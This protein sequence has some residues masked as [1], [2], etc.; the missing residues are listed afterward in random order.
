MQLPCQY[1]GH[2]KRFEFNTIAKK[3]DYAPK[4]MQ[5]N[6]KKAAVIFIVS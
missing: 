3:G 5:L 1:T 2:P 6:A 4:I